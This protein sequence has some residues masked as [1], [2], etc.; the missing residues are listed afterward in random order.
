MTYLAAEFFDLGAAV[1]SLAPI[2]RG[3]SI[4]QRSAL[5]EFGLWPDRARHKSAAAIGADIIQHIVHAIRT[6]GAFIRADHRVLRVSR[7][8]TVA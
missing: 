3:G 4:G 1:F 7:Q 2:G 8:V 5:A 6:E